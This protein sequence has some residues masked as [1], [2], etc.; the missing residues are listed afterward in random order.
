VGQDRWEEIDEGF[1]GANYGWPLAEG[2]SPDP[3]F[4][5]PIH[6]YPVASIAGGAFCPTGP[7]SNFPPQFRGKYFFAD[8]VKGWIK[9]LDPDRPERV[10]TFA[11]GLTRPV[12]LKFGPNGSLDVLLRDAW[13]KDQNFRPGTGSLHRIRFAAKTEVG[14]R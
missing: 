11:T 7:G 6:T 2:P 9:V 14:T 8:F 12:D 1:A 4:R 3:R 5:G 10:E 13:V